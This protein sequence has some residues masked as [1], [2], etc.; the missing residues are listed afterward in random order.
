VGIWGTLPWIGEFLGQNEKDNVSKETRKSF[1]HITYHFIVSAV[2]IK[3]HPPVSFIVLN[4]D[5]DFSLSYH[6]VTTIITLCL[7]IFYFCQIIN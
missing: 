1:G 4:S 6:T 2:P 5:C 7:F 3:N